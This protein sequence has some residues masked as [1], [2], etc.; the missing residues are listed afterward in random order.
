MLCQHFNVTPSLQKEML[1]LFARVVCRH[2]D[3]AAGGTFLSV[4]RRQES[5]D[6]REQITLRQVSSIL[7]ISV[8]KIACT[9]KFVESLQNENEQPSN[10]SKIGENAVGVYNVCGLVRSVLPQ[11]ELH[12]PFLPSV[13]I[14]Q[15]VLNL[16]EKTLQLV[17]R[18]SAKSIDPNFITIAAGY[19]AWQSC[20]FYQKVHHGHVPLE[21][22][23]TPS[24]ITTLSEYLILARLTTSDTL[25]NSVQRTYNLITKE[26]TQL[27]VKMP[28]INNTTKK[29]SVPRYLEQILRCQ[30][31]TCDV[32]QTEAEIKRQN[33]PIIKPIVPR[34]MDLFLSLYPFFFVISF[35]HFLVV[36]MDCKKRTESLLNSRLMSFSFPVSC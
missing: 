26:L 8:P 6:I 1:N 33:E 22:L 10:Q 3:A 24:K 15:R 5:R 11:F 31:L 25:L 32:L 34:G 7:G 23:K 4:I 14:T 9:L 21:S 35:P 19:L 17:Q 36:L 27:L 2:L 30:G 29:T 16:T 12:D 18:R 28:W 20:F 13:N